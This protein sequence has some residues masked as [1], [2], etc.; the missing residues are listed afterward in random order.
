MRKGEGELPLAM[1]PSVKEPRVVCVVQCRANDEGP[2]ESIMLAV[3]LGIMTC[4]KRSSVMSCL[5]SEVL[6]GEPP[7]VPGIQMLAA[8]EE[9][10][11]CE[12]GKFPTWVL[13]EL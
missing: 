3:S 4:R 12:S 6:H 5:F 11:S 10:L 1:L 7:V 9:N 8:K 2:W 13:L